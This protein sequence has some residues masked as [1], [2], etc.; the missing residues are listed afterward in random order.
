MTEKTL[1]Q[2]I[3]TLVAPEI[4][5]LPQPQ[6]CEVTKT[7]TD[8]YVD[9]GTPYNYYQHV[10]CFGD[11]RV[12]ATGVLIFLNAE[13]TSQKAITPYS[14]KSSS[15]WE[16]VGES[17]TRPTYYSLYVNPLTRLVELFISHLDPESYSGTTDI[18][19][20]IGNTYKPKGL[21]VGMSNKDGIRVGV[22]NTGDVYVYGSVSANTNV[23]ASVMWH[24]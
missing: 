7:Y 24:Y 19:L 12:G 16:V 14:T 8:G 22:S 20:N 6:Y 21:V 2:E 3:L 18:G 5:K 23:Q 15:S 11:N 10:E 9:V 13:E 1:A 17:T 4:E